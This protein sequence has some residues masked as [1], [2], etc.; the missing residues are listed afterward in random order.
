[1]QEKIREIIQQS[2]LVKQD[3]LEYGDLLKRIG[4]IVEEIVPCF[5][6]GHLVYF[7]V[8]G[9]V[10]LMRNILQRNSPDGFIRI[11]LHYLQKH[12]IAIQVILQQ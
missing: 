6:N 7:V 3:V 12:C 4:K 1:M 8:T 5:E 10:P 2:I 11:V 9:A